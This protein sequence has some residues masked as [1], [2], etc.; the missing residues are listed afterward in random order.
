MVE[1]GTQEIWSGYHVRKASENRQYSA[2]GEDSEPL[3][4]L[5]VQ[6]MKRYCLSAAS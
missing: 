2:G 5:N 1:Q 6:T 4:Y 3:D